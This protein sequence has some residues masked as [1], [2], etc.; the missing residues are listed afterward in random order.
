MTEKAILQFL[1][2]LKPTK[3]PG[4]DEPHSLLLYSRAN[5]I[6]GPLTMLFNMLLSLTQ[7]LRHC[8]GDEDSHTFE[9]ERDISYSDTDLSVQVAE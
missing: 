1:I 3:L 6:T 4:S 8:K 9:Y 5:T 2:N 7:L